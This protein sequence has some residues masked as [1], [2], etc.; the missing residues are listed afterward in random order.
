[1][2]KQRVPFKR[3]FEQAQTQLR[4]KFGMQM[5]ELPAKEKITMKDKRCKLFLLDRCMDANVLLAA[6]KVKGNSKAPASYILTTILPSQYRTAEILPPSIIGS[7]AEEAAYTG[8]CSMAVAL[9]SLSPGRSLP[10]SKLYR[11]LSRMNADKNM[12]MG[13]TENV[14]K[15]MTSQG[16]L[17]KVLDRSGDEETIDWV[18]G[19]RGKIEI[20]NRGILGLVK[21]VYGDRAP[22]D[23]QDRMIRSLGIVLTEDIMDIGVDRPGEQVEAEEENGEP[24]EQRRRSGR[25]R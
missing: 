1:M 16:Y 15:M 20:G 9:I 18:V 19:P 12:P 13:K 17:V 5:V 7:S 24:S 22:D 25:V 11:Y 10:D 6:Q 8:L 14:M 2:L 21:E 23:L 3:V 4:T